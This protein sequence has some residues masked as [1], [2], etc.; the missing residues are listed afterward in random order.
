[1]KRHKLNIMEESSK[2]IWFKKAEALAKDINE[3][4]DIDIS[5]SLLLT[6][7]KIRNKRLQSKS[8]LFIRYA[9]ILTLP[10]LISS[11]VLGYMVLNKPVEVIQYAQVKASAGTVIRYELPDKSVVWLNAGSILKYPTKFSKD[12]RD[13]ELV[14][15]AYFEVSANK[16]H[17]FYVHTSC[18]MNVFAYGTKFNVSAYKDDKVIETVLANGNVNIITPNRKVAV[19]NPGEQITFDKTANKFSKKAVDVYEKI[20]WKEGKMIFRDAPLEIMLKKLARHFNVTIQLN[21]KYNRKYRYRA[22]FKNET[23]PQI[24]NYLAKSASLKWK[25]QECKQND[26]N[27]L[28]EEKIII[29]LY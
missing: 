29:D 18:G 13:V 1:M 8:N 3:M 9:A 15:E 27:T 12:R 23:L 22:T 16:K 17:P 10:L 7:K 14:G 20:A 25:I 26:D 11:I 4:E 6:Q 28:T 21:N 19:M 2:D 5:K 24:L